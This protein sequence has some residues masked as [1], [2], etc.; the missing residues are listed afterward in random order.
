MD[1]L[2]VLKAISDESRMKILTLLLQHNYC[3]RALAR[4]LSLSEAAISQ[5]LKILRDAGLLTGEKRGYFMHYDVNRIILHELAANIEQLAVIEREICNPENGGCHISEQ[6][7]C[8]VQK[9]NCSPEAGESYHESDIE[10][11]GEELHGHGHCH[12]HKP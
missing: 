5:H 6:E 7:R 3:V 2:L 11:K 1:Q 10:T 9:Q 4:K 8:H 12:C